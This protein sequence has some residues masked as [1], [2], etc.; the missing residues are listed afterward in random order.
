M[1]QRAIFL[2]VVFGSA[3]SVI[4]NPNN[5]PK[6]H[7][8]A[9]PPDAP[10]ADANPAA[11]M[12][13]GVDTGAL[14]EGEGSDG[15]RPEVLV[16]RGQN[17]IPDAQVTITAMGSGDMP[18][19]SL[20]GSA[21]VSS[22]HTL[23]AVPV[24]ADVNTT[25]PA[26]G[27]NS[28]SIALVVTVTQSGGTVT[29]TIPW[30]LTCLPEIDQS[31]SGA[32]GSSI[33]LPPGVNNL[34]R[35]VLAGSGS[36]ILLGSGGNPTKPL[37]VRVTGRIEV[38]GSISVSANNS[39]AG[40]GGDGPAAGSGA[41]GN[42]G[43]GFIILGTNAGAG[44][45]GYAAPGTQGQNNNSS[46]GP[47]VG[48]DSVPSFAT[49]FAS[50]GGN[51]DQTSG[52]AGG[53]SIELTAGGS[54]SVGGIAAKGAKGG[55]NAGGGAGGT[56]V[57]RAGTT[58]TL[59]GN[60]DISGGAANSLGGAGAMGRVRINTPQAVQGNGS[61]VAS[62]A[63]PSAYRGLAFD[64]TV[65]FITTMAQPKLAI[66]GATGKQYTLF[67]RDADNNITDTQMGTLGADSANVSPHLSPGL[68]N[69][70]LVEP[71]GDLGDLE[72]VTCVDIAYV[73]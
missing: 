37:T 26:A 61:V 53:G 27:S 58:L 13:S 18:M 62:G 45:A 12:L 22:D 39:T 17:I 35:L 60:L 63:S 73:P 5:I 25:C 50:G 31:G 54:L 34:S 11:L 16:V 47:A 24:E 3:C 28:G 9:T 69:V 72:G 2:A 29:Q 40:P 4:Y 44:G 1:G 71:G 32:T 30:T 36:T 42:G 23:L 14:L 51:Y 55:T 8:D 64:P 65:P 59:N 48:S 68:N 15:S 66:H 33:S 10:P 41:G 70:C 6:P 56:I 7:A 38:P 43:A 57:V 20:A 52:G 49:N 46:G 67:T 19:V 21:A